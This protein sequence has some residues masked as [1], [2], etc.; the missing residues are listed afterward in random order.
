MGVAQRIFDMQV[1]DDIAVSDEAKRRVDTARV[2][3]MAF[4]VKKA[5]P[6]IGADDA[7]LLARAMLD[8]RDHG[9]AVTPGTIHDRVL[10]ITGDAGAATRISGLI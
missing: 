8:A 4:R 2:G 9:I 5:I 1:V 10:E 7:E 6:A 3:D